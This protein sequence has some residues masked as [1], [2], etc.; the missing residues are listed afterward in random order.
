MSVPFPACL[1]SQVMNAF[2]SLM[3]VVALRICDMERTS[4]IGTA[5][6]AATAAA[7]TGVR[8]NRQGSA[9]VP[10]G[11][12]TALLKD[13]RLA[14]RVLLRTKSWTAVVLVSL[15]LGIGA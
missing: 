12:M 8:A 5:A 15:A 9:G 14:F 4:A 2:A 1:S 6:P 11:H 10:S 13:L 7:P 3:C